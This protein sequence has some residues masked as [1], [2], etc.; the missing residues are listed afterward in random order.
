MTSMS[1]VS[2][3]PKRSPSY[4]AFDLEASIK[5]A[6][7]LYAAEGRNP[8]PIETAVRHWGYK[9]PSGRTNIL[10]SSLKKFGLIVDS[11]SGKSRVIQVSDA[12][13]RILEHPEQEERRAAI[14][15]AALLP[16]IH[17]EMWDKYKDD[18]PSDATLIWNL[19]TDRD[20]T[21]VGAKDFV[22]EYRATI[23]FSQ[24]CDPE[25]EHSEVEGDLEDAAGDEVTEAFGD[26][27]IRNAPVGRVTEGRVNDPARIRDD[28]P[29]VESVTAVPIPLPGGGSITVQGAFPVSETNWDY[30]MAV[31]SVMK[32]GLV[33]PS[34]LH[35]G[36]NG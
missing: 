21:D 3:P 23:A 9:A 30:W 6:R 18:L 12:A 29:Y 8:A 15:K 31:L 25:P 13:L 24:L 10:V 28:A 17:R 35:P 26:Q 16:R 33:V 19:K 5:R 2:A 1:A 7:E 20:F 4:P 36:G 27:L 34:S 22:K 14:Q 32:P 11:G